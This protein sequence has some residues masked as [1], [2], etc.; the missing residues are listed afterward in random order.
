MVDSASYIALANINDSRG[1]PAMPDDVYAACLYVLG[2]NC[3]EWAPNP[4][5][6][7]HALCP[8]NL[9]RGHEYSL[10]VEC[11]GVGRQRY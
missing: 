10:C 2:I 4:L 6:A 3:F 9:Q 5:P 1:R 7:A 11:G 8:I